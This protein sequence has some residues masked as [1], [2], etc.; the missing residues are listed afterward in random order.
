MLSRE[1]NLEVW[2]IS[3]GNRR[4]DLILQIYK[5]AAAGRG[6]LPPLVA[7]DPAG[8]PEFDLRVLKMATQ[9]FPRAEFGFTDVLFKKK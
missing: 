7:A 1:I 8:K 4:L 5:T 9:R 3:V 2:G 6:T